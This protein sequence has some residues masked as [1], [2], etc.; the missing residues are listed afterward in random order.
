VTFTI[1]A[2]TG[3]DFEVGTAAETFLVV[4]TDDRAGVAPAVVTAVVLDAVVSV[5]M[6]VVG[7][8]SDDVVVPGMPVS[9]AG[10][11]PPPHPA[12]TKA[13]ATPT[14]ARKRLVSHLTER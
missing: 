7:A 4:V 1:P 12:A 6:V 5:G 13:N 8:A 10:F 9:A 14:S 3:L 2:V 11:L